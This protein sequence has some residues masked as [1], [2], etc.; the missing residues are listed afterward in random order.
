MAEQ[1]QDRPRV[2]VSVLVR[3]G[4]RILLVKRE[5]V[6]QA[7]SWGAPGGSLEYGETFEHRGRQEVK[8]ETGVEIRDITFR[9]ITND[10]FEV[11][12][13]HFIT[14]WMEAQYVSGEAKVTAPYEESE[15][16]WFTWNTLPQPLFLP[17]QH[18]LDNETFPIQT[19]LPQE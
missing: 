15:V 14:V 8:E 5:H 11:E 2:G 10:V 18:L 4:D 13:K 6:H 9:V 16:G 17:L 3:D 7:G 19:K 1:K 12:H